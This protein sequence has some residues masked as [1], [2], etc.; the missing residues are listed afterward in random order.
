MDFS[1][2]LENRRFKATKSRG[3]ECEHWAVDELR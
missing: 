3:V 2:W 1:E